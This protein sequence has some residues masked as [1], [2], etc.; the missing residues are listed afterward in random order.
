MS[1]DDTDGLKDGALGNDKFDAYDRAYIRVTF[2]KVIAPYILKTISIITALS[3]L[4]FS[5]YET[6]RTFAL[7]ILFG[8]STD[9]LNS[10]S[11]NAQVRRSRRK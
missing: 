2:F 6:E 4:T 8:S 5:P 10:S 11:N 7:G 3:V 9:A 1:G